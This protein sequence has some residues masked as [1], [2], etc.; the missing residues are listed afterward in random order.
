[1]T[2]PGYIASGLVLLY[3]VMCGVEVQAACNTDATVFDCDNFNPNLCNPDLTP[4]C[5]TNGTK[6]SGSCEAKRAVCVEHAFLDNTNQACDPT[7]TT[8]AYPQIHLDCC[9]YNETSRCTHDLFPICLTNGTRVYGT[10][11]ALKAVCHEYAHIDQTG[12]LCPG[13]TTGDP[14]VSY[15]ATG[16]CT[17]DLLPFCLTNGTVVLGTC[18][19][20]Q[21]VC[22]EHAHIDNT[23]HLCSGENTESDCVSYN[24]SGRCTHDLIPHCLT[25]G[26]MVF[27]TCS[28]LKAVCHEHAHIDQTGH[29][30]P[31]ENTED[32]C[33]SYIATGRCT[34]DLLPFCLSN[35]TRVFGTC[36]ALQAVC[37]EHA[38]IDQTGLLCPGET[39]KDAC[40][41]YNATNSCPHDLLP[42][43]LTNGTMV[44]GTCSAL[45]A[46]CH[47]HA[48]ARS[49]DSSAA[50]SLLLSTFDVVTVIA[51]CV[52]AGGMMK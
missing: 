32:P 28:L 1:M 23:G 10:C 17:Q 24:A 33:V 14:C 26:T 21:A 45:K 46:V 49:C 37:R 20:L 40:V 3:T 48:T 41:N 42:F 19:A 22:H 2:R 16:H 31:G 38:S 39:T 13:V 51:V 6:V 12:H 5:L 43:C 36:S 52:I 11:S 18:S 25:N 9:I 15:T 4:F 8:A 35:G 29:L 47:E 30:C 7:A 34:H 44:F 27:G 50:T